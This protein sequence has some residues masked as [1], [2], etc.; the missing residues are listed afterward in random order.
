MRFVKKLCEIDVKYKKL[1]LHK[2]NKLVIIKQILKIVEIK[3][4][5]HLTNRENKGPW[6]II[7]HWNKLNL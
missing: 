4:I 2:H 1:S 5:I 7:F 6:W 3:V